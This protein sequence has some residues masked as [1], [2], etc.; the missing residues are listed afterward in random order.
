MKD[1]TPLLANAFPRV[2]DI[3][4]GPAQY[5]IPKLKKK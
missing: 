2:I 3:I 4:R 5:K 1:G